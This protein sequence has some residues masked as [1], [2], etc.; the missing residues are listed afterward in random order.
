MR[1][2]RPEADNPTP[3]AT[4]PSLQTGRRY[5]IRDKLIAIF[6]VIKVLPLVALALFAARQIGL[7]GNTF[8]EKSSAIAASTRTLVAQTGQLAT[9][10]SIIALDL[11]ARESIER[12]TT[13]IAAAVADFLHDR[14]RDILLAANLEPDEAHY[15]RFL[16]AY[17]RAVIDHPPWQLSKDGSRWAPEVTPAAPPSLVEPG[18]PDNRKDFH[19]LPP[20]TTINRRQTPLYHEMTFVDLSG[21][22]RVKVSMTDLLP[23]D[24]RDI[25]RRE[26]T[27]CG[28]ETYFADLIAHGPG[29]IAVSRVIG[30]YLPSPIIGPY[31]PEQAAK[32]GIPFAPEQAGYAGKE[33]PVGKR[34][35]GIVRWATP[36]FKGQQKIG[37]VTLALDHTHLMEFTDHVIPTPER[38]SAISDA[39]SGNYA[40]MW[41]DQGRNISHPRDYFI[42]GF[43]PRTGE[44]AVPWLSEELASL[45]KEAEG[46]FSRFEQL[47]PRFLEQTQSKKPIAELTSAGMLGLDCR[48]L[49][50]AP[51]C[52]GWY[53]LTEYGGSGSFLILWS[54]LWK[55]T[56]AAAIPYHTG[57]YNT[58]RGFGFVTIGANVDEFHAAANETA[59]R[60][61]TI[62]REY[63]SFL[64]QNRLETLSGIE[65]RLRS[66]ITNLSV[67]TGIMIVLVILIAVWMA[68]ALTGKITAIIQGIKRFQSGLLDTRLA[69]GSRDEMGELA[70]ALNVMAGQL[71]Q[72]MI[73]LEQAK[74]RAEQS[75]Q[76]KSLFLANMSHEIR[77]PM[78]AIIGMTSLAMQVNDE[79]KRRRFLRTIHQ[80]AQSLFALLN[81]I[82]DCS[83]MEAGQ[84]QLLPRPFSLRRLMG[85]IIAT[86]NMAAMEKGLKLQVRIDPRLPEAFVGDDLRL[87]QILINLVGNAIKF[88]ETGTID[89]D[90]APVGEVAENGAVP[91]LFTVRDTG[92]GIPAGQ[93]DRIFERFEQAD[94]SYARQY[95]GAGLGLAICSQL[96]TLMGGRIHAHSQEHQ[97]SAFHVELT[98]PAATEDERSDAEDAQATSRPQLKGLHILVVDDNEVNR[99]VAGMTL[100]RHH[101]VRTASNGLEALEAL[102]KEEIDV[103]LM[104]VQMPLMD[105]LTATAAIRALENGREPAV[106]LNAALKSSL[107]QKLA[108]GHLAIVAMTAHAMAG[109]RE[110]CLAAGMDGYLTKPFQPEQLQAALH[111][112]FSDTPSPAS[113]F[114]IKQRAPATSNAQPP[115]SPQRHQVRAHLE[116][117]T[118]LRPEQIDR[119][120]E[121]AE[122]SINGC[123]TQ[124]EQ[125]LQQHDEQALARIAHTLKGTLLQC[126][127]EHWAAR[128]QD[129]HSGIRDQ[130]PLP[131]ALMVA[132]LRQ[133]LAALGKPTD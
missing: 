32:A 71:R 75:D 14:D 86:M 58:P 64:E 33:N 3:P 47:A 35:Q 45:W 87:R 29:Q 1:Q 77:T 34:F 61:S 97:G 19:A 78:N 24:L 94:S 106:H 31:T 18:S 13:D 89:L 88:T 6:V 99:D 118:R 130:Q 28:A 105:G 110:K 54:D 107:Q 98:L 23:S 56:T 7:L 125:A 15:R 123:L 102:T 104:D 124:A 108:G 41:D 63:E 113:G 117:T 10:S 17:H 81:D 67:S 85:G 44:Q 91:L 100:A 114:S 122:R 5:G 42:V 30:A 55:L 133:G 126:G 4:G 116:A 36:V 95:G 121:A 103:V 82:L 52:I 69:V 25:S 60:I 92:I 59:A 70:E 119:I 101:H 84:L 39:G 93:L 40:F 57:R 51:Q 26:N 129:I 72:S 8:K 27:W 37:Y 112:A 73:E 46:S 2:P 48:Y 9:E 74:E 128:A 53:N 11:K 111:D 12:L 83:K 68:A 50:F 62:T 96:V 115:P 79:K 90:V 80:S 21:R 120:L 109:D 16:A 127:L 131:Y 49:N 132:E 43:D 22:E 66:T 65:T 38:F 20:L 76:A